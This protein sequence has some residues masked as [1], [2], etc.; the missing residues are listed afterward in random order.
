MIQ[1]ND[2]NLSDL[3]NKSEFDL[4][5]KMRNNTFINDPSD[6][7]DQINDLPHDNVEI[8]CSYAEDESFF[9]NI[10]SDENLSFF[11]LNIQSLPAKFVEFKD[12]LA[13]FEHDFD[14]ISLQ[15]IW[16]IHDED[17]FNLPGY[18]SV[19]RSR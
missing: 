8:N 17:I 4:L 19:F 9:S 18:T 6:P 14:I 13:T 2:I 1:V 12:L 5:S 7:N 3:R 10:K 16:R 11:S 15:E